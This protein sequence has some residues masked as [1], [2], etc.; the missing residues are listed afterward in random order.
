MKTLNQH[1]RGL[2]AG[3]CLALA[4]FAAGTCVSRADDWRYHNRNHD[5]EGYWDDHHGY[6]RY[7]FYHHRRGYWDERNGVRIFI[8]V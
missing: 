7:E 5:S 8:S 3:A 2:L 1:H 4:L 6:H